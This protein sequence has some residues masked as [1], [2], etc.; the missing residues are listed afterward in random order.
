MKA[1][2]T[3]LV[4]LGCTGPVAAAPNHPAVDASGQA[5]AHAAFP[6]PNKGTVQDVIHTDTYSYIQ[7]SGANGPVW[8]ATLKL[9]VAKGT[10]IAYSEGTVMTD[11]VSKTLN[12]TFKSI[13]FVEKVIVE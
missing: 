4:L 3:L 12:R 7:V 8:I 10:H 5:P 6:T 9:D 2:L 13:I 1:I 11:F